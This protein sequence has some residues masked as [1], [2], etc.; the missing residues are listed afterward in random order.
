MVIRPATR[1]DTDEWLRMRSEL[2]PDC[3][4][5]EHISEINGYFVEQD[6][7]AVFV[8]ERGDGRLAGFVELSLR[9]TAESCSS[10]PVGYIEGWYVD[11]DARRSGRGRALVQAGEQWAA[12]RGCT[13]MASDTELDNTVSQLAHGRLG[14]A[15]VER[16]VHFRKSLTSE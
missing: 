12:E 15:E 8:A 2:W 13:E 6:D 7:I 14:Y 10:H 3:P 4:R 1:N 9:S 5:T 11:P 16:L